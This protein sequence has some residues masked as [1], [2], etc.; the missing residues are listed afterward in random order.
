MESAVAYSSM[1][2]IL[3]AGR[4]C[5]RI[6]AATR[7]AFLID[8]EAYYSALRSALRAARHSILIVGWDIDSRL[9]LPRVGDDRLPET[10]GEFLNTLVARRDALHAHVLVWDFALIYALERDILPL[11]K[12]R[13]RAHRRL[14]FRMNDR[15]PPG[16]SQHEKIVV[17]DDAVAFV[18]GFDLGKW[19]WDTRDH[20]PREP[21]RVDPDGK[22]YA[23]FHDVQMVVDDA[24]ASAVADRARER[25]YRATG[26]ALKPFPASDVDPWPDRITPHLRNVEV[27]VARTEP[28]YGDVT[29]VREVERL[30]LDA[31]A[32]AQRTV[33]IENQYLTSNAVGT[34]LAA[35]LEAAQGPEVVLVLPLKTG[36]WLEQT[37]MDV[38]RARLLE[39]LRAADRHGRLRVFWPRI[40][41]LPENQCLSL[42][43][44]LLFVDDR[45]VRVGSSN[46]SNRSMGLDTECDLA[47]E[48][49]DESTAQAIERVRNELIAEHLGTAPDAVSEALRTHGSLIAAIEAL[50]GG[51]R[52]LEVLEGSVPAAV[53]RE[54]PDSAIIDPE[55]P[56]EAEV[57]AERLIYEEERAPTRRRVLSGVAT[58]ILLLAL[59]A[60][61]RWTPLG[62]WLDVELISAWVGRLRESVLGPGVAVLAFIAGGLVVMPVTLLI[63]VTALVFGPVSGFVYSMLGS[64]MSGVVSYGIGR[65]LGRHAVRQLAG[66]RI[67]RLSRRLARRGVMTVATLR[68]IPVAPFTVVNMVAGA[69]HIG[70]RDFVVG[71][72]LGM[73]PGV[74]AFTL[75]ADRLQSVV[76]RPGP[77]TI[78]IFVAVAGIIALGGLAANRWLGK[79]RDVA[80]ST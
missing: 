26:E 80:E 34:A 51:E 19:R 28:A 78:V 14:H 67:N 21:R 70:F 8:G 15:H 12:L 39:R 10:L 57:L 65:A 23:P 32:A 60:A 36:G 33:Y 46:M 44:K 4:N 63:I 69:S 22:P 58:L 20:A 35:R 17:I 53:E 6:E 37:T 13:W 49:R 76:T 29:E 56:L 71:T 11:Y 72:A 40:P 43:A 79:R 41:G 9:R 68:L 54:V 16:A 62:G 75:F 7:V 50:R 59:A 74:G 64:V 61:W 47:V 30:H 3:E 42:H 48:A 2:R 55:R 38:L 77:G 31:I 66:E 25:W 27:G 5:W 18:G 24:A 52:T 1:S 45:L 73:I